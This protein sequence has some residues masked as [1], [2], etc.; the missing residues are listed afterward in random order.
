MSISLMPGRCV[1][2]GTLGDQEDSDDDC[3]R[4]VRR[5]KVNYLNARA[6]KHKCSSGLI[7][8]I[9]VFFVFVRFRKLTGV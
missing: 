2:A 4:I 8:T 7:W 9:L 1:F 3:V 5:R 6:W